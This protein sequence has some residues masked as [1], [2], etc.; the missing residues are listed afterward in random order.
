MTAVAPARQEWIT[1]HLFASVIPLP[2]KKHFKKKKLDCVCHVG[3]LPVHG[4]TTTCNHVDLLVFRRTTQE[5][6]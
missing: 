3:V 5:L 4:L 6:H 2:A 1:L